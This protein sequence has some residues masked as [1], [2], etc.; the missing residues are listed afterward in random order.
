MKVQNL[1][2]KYSDHPIIKPIIEHCDKRCM[3]FELVKETRMINNGGKC[4]TS[5]SKYYMQ[6]GDKLLNTNQELYFWEDLLAL[7]INAYKYLGME[8]PESLERA[9]KLFGKS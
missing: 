2:N 3:S 1:R 9:A 8:S 7:L 5:V 6:I 4:Y